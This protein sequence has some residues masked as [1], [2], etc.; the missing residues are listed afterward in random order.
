MRITLGS[1]DPP[2]FGASVG[3]EYAV[4][5]ERFGWDDAALTELTR[6]AI[7]ASFAEPALRERLLRRIG[8][9]DGDRP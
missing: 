3:G 4:A 6:T 2:Y 5:R 7:A 8:D 1:D 9:G